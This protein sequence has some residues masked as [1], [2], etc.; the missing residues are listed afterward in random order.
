VL[1]LRTSVTVL[2]QDIGDTSGG[3]GGD[4]QHPDPE[5]IPAG[6]SAG[7]IMRKLT[8][9]GIFTLDNVRYLVDAQH[10]FDEILVVQDGNQITVVDPTAKSPS[11][12]PGQHQT[13]PTSADSTA[14]DPPSTDCHPCPDTHI[15][16]FCI[17][18]SV[19]LPGLLVAM[20]GWR[21][22]VRPRVSSSPD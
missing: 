9:Q 1:R 10:R 18:T 19:T 5:R 3:L 6:L 8:S 17:R 14:T 11:K 21:R 12:P 7:T 15:T 22:G 2:C 20:A 13:S 16:R 4:K